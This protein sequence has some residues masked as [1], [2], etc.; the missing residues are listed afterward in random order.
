M[1]PPRR[2]R[3]AA[4]KEARSEDERGDLDQIE[5]I[6][7]SGSNKEVATKDLPHGT[8]RKYKQLN[9]KLRY[10]CGKAMAKMLKPLIITA[11]ATKCMATHTEMNTWEEDIDH[12]SC[13][14]LES[15]KARGKAISCAS[16]LKDF[17]TNP[18]EAEEKKKKIRLISANVHALRPRAEILKSWEAD[19][20]VAQ[21]TKL[22]PHAIG[23]VARI[24]KDNGWSIS[25]GRP[26]SHQGPRKNTTRTHAATE[27]T[28]G[29]LCHPDQI[30][31]KAFS[32]RPK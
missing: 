25:H 14:L 11:L 9:Q 17:V 15:R 29:G 16:D 32:E 8:R 19:I 27:A 4:A 5:K 3:K 6:K 23:D 28:S 31:Q 2:W 24:I 26:C 30:P 1:T 13:N 18:S 12:E 22:A 10:S 21:E 20:I 7:A